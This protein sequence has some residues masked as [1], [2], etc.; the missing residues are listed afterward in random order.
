MRLNN[1]KV[2]KLE[3]DASERKFYRSKN[4][5]IIVSKK[6]K[7][8]LVYPTPE[9]NLHVSRK[10]FNKYLSQEYT[11]HTKNNSADLIRNVS[12]VQAI[13]NSINNILNVVSEIIF[14]IFVISFE[15]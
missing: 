3:G 11:F 1:K 12:S 13:K 6:N 8:I 9:N 4:S 10:L 14:L 15:K 2:I 7:I 5:I